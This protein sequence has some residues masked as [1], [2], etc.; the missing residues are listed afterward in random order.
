MTLIFTGALGV[1]PVTGALLTEHL[2]TERAALNLVPLSVV[3]VYLGFGI[4]FVSWIRNR[5]HLQ[6]IRKKRW[7][8]FSL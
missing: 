1:M 6:T 3:A 4:Y 8:E 2:V 7:Y 5:R